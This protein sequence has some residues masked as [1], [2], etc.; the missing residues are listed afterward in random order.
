MVFSI[1]VDDDDRRF[2]ETAGEA[3]A[4]FVP[5]KTK[6]NV[7]L[8]R[9]VV[10]NDL[11]RPP[12]G[13][14]LSRDLQDPAATVTRATFNSVPNAGEYSFLTNDHDL[15]TM[16]NGDILYITGAGSRRPLN[17]RPPWFDVTYRGG[18]GPGAR[19][20]V[21]VWRSTDGAKTFNFVSE[22][23][24]ARFADGSAALPQFPRLTTP[25]GTAAKP[26]FD[27]GGSDGQ[28]A[29]VDPRTKT[30]YVT[31]QAVGFR[32]NTA[33]T[34]HFELSNTRL[35][36][37]WVFASTD[38]GTTWSLIGSLPVAA[39]RIHVVPMAENRLAFGVGTTL[40]IGERQGGTGGWLLGAVQ[41]T[42][43]DFSWGWE[44]SFESSTSIKN[45]RRFI[46]A[47]MH[48][49]T[50]VVGSYWNNRAALIFPDTIT[51]SSGNTSHGYRVFY[52]TRSTNRLT[53]ADPILPMARSTDNWIMHL[54]VIDL[55]VPPMDRGHALLY[56]YDMSGPKQSATVRGRVIAVDGERSDDFTISMV[57]GGPRSFNFDQGR[58]A[59]W[60]G[61]YHT[62]DGFTGSALPNEI[63]THRYFPMWVEPDR[64]IRYT[65]VQVRQGIGSDQLSPTQTELARPE[66]SFS[67]EPQPPQ[68]GPVEERIVTTYGQRAVHPREG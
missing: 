34:D 33:I 66:P 43:S 38:S 29:Y 24:P 12:S 49:H 22:I 19:S 57:G 68:R 23:D 5:P 45:A 47:N 4:T 54:A 32:R 14:V 15:V 11:L 17:P 46:S 37:T 1:K 18:F 48:A 60:Y 67:E 28:L 58:G 30:V 25:P 50:L 55:G 36:F 41:Q 3:Q 21:L 64:T 2:N 61:D 51:D 53:E 8:G 52:Y 59:Y 27:M 39:W 31:F 7:T 13:V 20:V 62:A 63:R 26:V 44:P 56:W 42:A 10:S 6:P 9:F 40:M 65:E 16:P 35:N